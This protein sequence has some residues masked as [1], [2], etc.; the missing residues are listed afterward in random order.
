[1]CP[2]WKLPKKKYFNQK[3]KKDFILY[4]AINQ[5]E[6][7][8]NLLAR[9]IVE[10][11][12]PDERYHQTPKKKTTTNEF[13]ISS[14]N[15]YKINYVTHLIGIHHINK[16]VVPVIY[17]VLAKIVGWRYERKVNICHGIYG[18]IYEEH[19]GAFGV[20]QLK[21]FHWILPSMIGIVVYRI[22]RL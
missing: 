20:E 16:I 3:S 2:N 8:E 11:S 17:S 10:F 9:R 15:G 13:F 21:I 12:I 14:F 1:M 18:K 6:R 7:K 5:N 19:D 4:F 22:L